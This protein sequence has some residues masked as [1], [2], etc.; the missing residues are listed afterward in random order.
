MRSINK[1]LFDYIY[2]EIGAEYSEDRIGV[3]LN[4]NN[5]NKK[6][7]QYLGTYFPRSYSEAYQIYR[8][9]FDNEK[10]YER[11]NKK[12]T[13]RILDIGSGTGGN[14]LGLIQ[15]LMEKFSDKSIYIISIEGNENAVEI[16]LDLLKKFGDFVNCNNNELH[17]SVHIIE[18]ACKDE[19]RSKLNNLSLDGTID[20]MQSFKVVNEFYRQDYK[21]NKGMYSELLKM[22][23]RWL[24]KS[25][26]LCL[27]DVTNPIQ[28][29]TYASILFN[30]EIRKYLTKNST[31]LVYIIPKCCALNYTE[32]DK[33]NNCFSCRTFK[34]RFDDFVKDSKVNYKL[35][36][37]KKLGDKV[38]KSIQE[39]PCGD[40]TCY[41]RDYEDKFNCTK[42]RKEPYIL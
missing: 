24:K 14:L 41:C 19:L 15:V 23:E 21:N 39:N 13:I 35:F 29:Q 32:C 9:L 1:K 18:F 4:L 10:I 42:K 30:E 17:G 36:I 22:G 6:N 20:I 37:K 26:M 25:G 2:D 8:N 34:I 7:L 11:F 38:L 33:R 5:D 12:N 28:G 16:Q 27:V 31:E 3:E 40:S